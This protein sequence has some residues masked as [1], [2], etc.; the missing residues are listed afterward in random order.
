MILC[1]IKFPVGK[2]IHVVFIAI[3]LHISRELL[4]AATD[5]ELNVNKNLFF[6]IYIKV[7]HGL[8]CYYLKSIYDIT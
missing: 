8:F 1:T 2:G 7:Y 4:N 3:Q 5:V 6:C